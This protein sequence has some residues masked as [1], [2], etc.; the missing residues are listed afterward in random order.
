MKKILLFV[1]LASS[2]GAYSQFWTE[3]ATGFTTPTRG[4]YSISI[5]DASVVWALA[6]D[7]SVEPVDLTIKEFTRSIDGGLTWTPGSMDL[8]LATNEL[9]ISSITAVSSTTAW[10][11]AYPD[12]FGT[13]QVGGIWK[14]TDSGLTWNKQN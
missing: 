10:V 2:L 13:T 11:S 4:L 12:T 9:G 5:V 3:K 1:L 7:S 8:G 6:S 14:T